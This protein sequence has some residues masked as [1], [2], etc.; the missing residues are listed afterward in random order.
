MTDYVRVREGKW[1]YSIPA[2]RVTDAVQIL[3]KPAV[4]GS[5]EAIP[6]KPVTAL[7]T[8]APGSKKDR[9]QQTFGAQ[10]SDENAGQTSATT[11]KE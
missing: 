11:E 1:E 10:G 3:D 6:P 9:T 4:A 7:G 2:H 8:P 5:G